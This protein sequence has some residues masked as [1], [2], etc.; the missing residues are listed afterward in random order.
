VT[1]NFR[2]FF[3]MSIVWL[4]L[5][6]LTGQQIARLPFGFVVVSVLIFSIPIALSG[7]YSS[8]VY[9]TR[10]LS[11]YKSSGTVFRLLSG[12]ALRSILWVLWALVTSFFMLVQFATFSDIAWV[13]LLLLIW[14]YWFAYRYSH[15]F[16]SIELKKRYVITDFSIVFVRWWCPAIMVVIYAGFILFFPSVQNYTS[17]SEAFAAKRSGMPEIAGSAVVQVTLQLMTFADGLKAYLAADLKQFGEYLPLLLK[18]VGGYV[19]FFNACATFAC[20]VIPSRE[21][22]RVFGPISEHDPPAALPKNQVALASALIALIAVFVYVPLFAQLEKWLEVDSNVVKAI[23]AGERLAER[24]D[25]E[26]YNPGTID[27]LDVAKADALGKLNL[28]R[29]KLE[30]QIDRAFDRM[31]NNVDHYL[32]WYYSLMAE[33]LRL[34]KLMTGEIEG[35]MENKLYEQLQ[36]G[37]TFKVVSDAIAVAI[38]QNSSSMEEYRQAAMGIKNGN[39]MMLPAGVEAKVVKEVSLRDS[40]SLP[41]HLDALAFESRAAS[42]AVAAGVSASIA[43]KVTSKG[44]FSAAAKVLSKMAASKAVA[45]FGGAA[46]GGAIGS[47]IPG[48]GTVTV[49]ALGGLF[50][51]L[52]IDGTLL[53]LEEAISRAEF[54]NEILIA[55][56][57]SKGVFKDRLFGAP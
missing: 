13:T 1:I 19:V 21:Y 12:R 7:A 8:A 42:G 50:A 23:K 39:R 18:L 52:V 2:S 37:E 32:D 16:L 4:V 57:E 40:F 26:L 15:R 34:A 27:K 6:Y 5:A 49:G 22:R 24:I 47:V 14:V 17:L 46:V 33:Y 48:V 35:Y 53:S 10:T 30:G 31:E 25:G 11:Y 9:Q 55:I 43:A 20:F 36:Q 3:F 41:T 38:A 28:S 45:V 56:Q 51:G 29:A 44:V 54:K